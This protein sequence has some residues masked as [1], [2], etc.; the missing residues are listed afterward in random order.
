LE[1]EDSKYGYNAPR[2]FSVTKPGEKIEIPDK[3]QLDFPCRLSEWMSDGESYFTGRFRSYYYKVRFDGPA[4]P[5]EYL[6]SGYMMNKLD[7]HEI[8]NS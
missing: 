3:R 2:S 8:L 5:S 4:T 7:N 6:T 1:K